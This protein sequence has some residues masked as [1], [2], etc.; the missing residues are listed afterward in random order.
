MTTRVKRPDVPG[1][2]PLRFD[3]RLS[4]DEYERLSGPAAQ[5]GVS[6]ARY[7]VEVVL[8]GCLPRDRQA[9]RADLRDVRRQVIGIAANVNQALKRVHATGRPDA[10]VR[11]AGEVEETLAR[12]DAAV[13]ELR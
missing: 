12:I 1:G 3:I 4:A 9:M 8:T 13:R 6:V 10:L 7:V 11:L 2:R 5:Q